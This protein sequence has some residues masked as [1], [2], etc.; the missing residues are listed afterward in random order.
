[1]HAAAASRKFSEVFMWLTEAAVS[2]TFYILPV[3]KD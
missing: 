3:I 1:M 2:I